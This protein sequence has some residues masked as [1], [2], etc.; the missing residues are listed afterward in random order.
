MLQVLTELGSNSRISDTW[1]AVP[2]PPSA[3]WFRVVVDGAAAPKG[4]MTNDSTQ[5]NFLRVSVLQS[6]RPF[7]LLSVSPSV[8]QPPPEA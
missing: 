4:S 2:V 8:C 1:S 3:D 7:I 5:G 6:I